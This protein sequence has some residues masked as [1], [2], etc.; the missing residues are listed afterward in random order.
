MAVTILVLVHQV[1]VVTV[2]ALLDAVAQSPQDVIVAVATT[3]LARMIVATVIVTTT[4]VT[5]EI[6]LVVRM[7]G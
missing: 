1:T 7:T 6:V 2:V 3:L 5:E 4:A